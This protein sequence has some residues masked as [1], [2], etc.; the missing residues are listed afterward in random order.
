MS[1]SGYESRLLDEAFETCGISGGVRA[2]T[3]DPKEFVQLAEALGW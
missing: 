1:H 2:E 3:L